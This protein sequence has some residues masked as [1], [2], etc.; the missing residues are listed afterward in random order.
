MLSTSQFGTIWP[1]SEMT[2]VLLLLKDPLD[3]FVRQSK[4]LPSYRFLSLTVTL[5][6]ENDIKHSFSPLGCITFEKNKLSTFLIV[7]VLLFP[8]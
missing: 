7:S 3:L 5:A 4:F 2:L 1:H 6:V 8:L